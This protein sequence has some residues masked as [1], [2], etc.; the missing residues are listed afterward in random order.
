MRASDLASPGRFNNAQQLRISAAK[1]ISRA[2]TRKDQGA[3]YDPALETFFLAALA[4]LT[5]LK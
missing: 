3:A 1:A 4:V 2:Q 5:A